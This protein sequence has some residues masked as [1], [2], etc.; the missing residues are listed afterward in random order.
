MHLPQ[1]NRQNACAGDGD[2]GIG[3]TGIKLGADATALLNTS[4]VRVIGIDANRPGIPADTLA[5]LG[6]TG[7]GSARTTPSA[8]IDYLFTAGSVLGSPIDHTVTSTK[9]NH[10]AVY[11]FLAL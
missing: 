4:T 10:L 7:R 5:G 2:K 11:A 3:G 9:S 6:L 8:R 1:E